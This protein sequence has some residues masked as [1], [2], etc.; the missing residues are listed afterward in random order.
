MCALNIGCFIKKYLTDYIKVS[1]VLIFA[2][3]FCNNHLHLIKVKHDAVKW[4]GKKSYTHTN[5]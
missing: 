4:G 2:K 5:E 3:N 1:F